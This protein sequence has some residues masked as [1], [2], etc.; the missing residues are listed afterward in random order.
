MLRLEGLE[1]VMADQK[2]G[3]RLL[4]QAEYDRAQRAAAEEQLRA[5]Q[6]EIANLRRKL[7]QSSPDE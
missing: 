1:L 2:T 3:E 6:A 4:T 7:R 5:A